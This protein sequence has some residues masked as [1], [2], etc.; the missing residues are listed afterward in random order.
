MLKASWDVWRRRMKDIISN[1]PSEHKIYSSPIVTSISFSICGGL[2][3][4]D[5]HFRSLQPR[6]L[7]LIPSF[8]D[9]VLIS[10]LS[11]DPVYGFIKGQWSFLFSSGAFYVLVGTFFNTVYINI[12]RCRNCLSVIKSQYPAFLSL[13]SSL[14]LVSATENPSNTSLHL[15]YRVLVAAMALPANTYSYFSYLWCF[16]EDRMLPTLI[17][18]CVSQYHSVQCPPHTPPTTIIFFMV[19]TLVFIFTASRMSAQE[20][21][22]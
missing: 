13:I 16:G 8:K 22:L 21:V 6:I 11:K 2:V 14:S 12:H 18:K 3:S 10:M 15:M 17:D 5:H 20:D 1:L 9:Y 4:K 19:Q 7:I